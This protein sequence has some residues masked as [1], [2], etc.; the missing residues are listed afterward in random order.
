M[1]IIRFL[2]F[3]GDRA[4]T[5]GGRVAPGLAHLWLRHYMDPTGSY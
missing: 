4:K 2:F 3:L 1:V 5:A